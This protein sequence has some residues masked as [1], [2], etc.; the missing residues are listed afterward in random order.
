MTTQKSNTT[1]ANGSFYTS[2]IVESEKTSYT[3]TLVIGKHSYLNIVKNNSPYMTAGK[4]FDSFD[5]AKKAY[6][7]PLVQ[8][9][10]VMAENELPVLTGPS[11]AAMN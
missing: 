6:K 5:A 7:S 8:L 4:N 1:E 3:F 9:M 11:K 2:I 10:M